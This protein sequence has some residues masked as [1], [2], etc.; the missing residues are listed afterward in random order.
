[1]LLSSLF[2]SWFCF[3]IYILKVKLRL[4]LIQMEDQICS[5]E[6]YSMK[7]SYDK[8]IFYLNENIF[9]YHE[10]WYNENTFYWIQIC[11][12]IMKIYFFKYK[13]ILIE[14]KYFSRHMNFYFCNISATI[15]GVDFKN[16][17]Y[18]RPKNIFLCKYWSPGIQTLMKKIESTRSKT[19]Y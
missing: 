17:V 16:L 13:V 3:S 18:L 8:N 7:N 12:N 14:W 2:T 11:F 9:I 4:L 10:S 19:I 1:M 15:H 5:P 6:K